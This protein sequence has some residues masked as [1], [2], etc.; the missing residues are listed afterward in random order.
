MGRWSE[1]ILQPSSFFIILHMVF[2]T[3][4]RNPWIGSTIRPR[5]QAHLATV[6]RNCDAV[7]VVHTSPR[8]TPWVRWPQNIPSAEGA[9]H[10][11]GPK[12][13]LDTHGDQADEPGLQPE[14]RITAMASIPRA[15]PL[16]WHESGLRPADPVAP[17][18]QVLPRPRQLSTTSKAGFCTSAAR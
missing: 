16:G 18:A 6:W 5:L 7:S 2:S 4:D 14:I 13:S 15:L 3:K 12:T 10:R 1:V 9:T 8:A 17:T 11:G